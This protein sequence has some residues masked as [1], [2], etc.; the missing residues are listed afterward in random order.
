MGFGSGSECTSTR[1]CQCRPPH[2]GNVIGNPGFERSLGLTPW[3]FYDPLATFDSDDA[4]SCSESGSARLIYQAAAWGAVK[5]CVTVAPN[6]SYWF[7]F[8]F[9]G[10]D[11]VFDAFVQFFA[12]DTCSGS[13]LGYVGLPT[14]ASSAA[15][16][17]Q[18]TSTSGTSPATAGSA[19]VYVQVS[20][21]ETGWVDSVYLNSEADS[22]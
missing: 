1:A 10:P 13:V 19:L 14:N 9:K 18:S 17:W 20:G 12:G 21:T 6:T 15:T 5:Q 2:P 16:Y 11:A 22:Y 3:T 8:K 4:D 7:G